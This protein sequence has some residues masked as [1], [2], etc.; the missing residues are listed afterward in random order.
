MTS[1][2]DD[3]STFVPSNRVT[4]DWSAHIATALDRTVVM[5]DSLDDTQWETQSLCEGWRVR[6]V[7]GH[8]VWR[9]GSST[10]EL[11]RTTARGIFGGRSFDRAV[12]SIARIEAASP[13]PE[14][15][16][17][18][19]RIAD[20]K[21]RGEG[22]TGIDELTEAIVHAIDISEAVGFPLAVSPRSTGAVVLSRVRR[23]LGAGR[24]SRVTL[25]ASDARWRIGSGPVV[26]APAAVLVASVFGRR[27]LP[28]AGAAGSAKTAS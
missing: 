20:T 4:G 17:Q 8:L 26:E 6:D 22:R 19:R 10:P 15:L 7:V 9:L 14:L 23:P 12:A 13:R 24:A 1:P 25:L 2:R 21:V 3:R 28:E 27:T 11:A 18:L 16:T 5:L